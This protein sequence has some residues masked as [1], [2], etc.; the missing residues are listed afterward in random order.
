MG[1]NGCRCE[2]TGEASNELNL[3]SKDR[4]PKISLSSTQPL[5]PKEVIVTETHLTEGDEELTVEPTSSETSE[6]G[7]EVS[8]VELVAELTTP[9]MQ[10][11]L[12]NSNFRN[13]NEIPRKSKLAK[14]YI[15]SQDSIS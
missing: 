10:K 1:N 7:S 11:V 4:L 2:R 6:E 15:R 8:I 9:K 13:K 14:E 12:H 3:A 5:T